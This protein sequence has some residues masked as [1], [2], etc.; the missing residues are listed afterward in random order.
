MTLL[1]QLLDRAAASNPRA[2]VLAYG[3]QVLTLSQLRAG[4]RSLA[5]WLSDTGVSPGDRVIVQA[6]NNP[7][8]AVLIYAIS[9]IGG[10]FIPVHPTTPVKQF[11]YIRENSGAVMVLSCRGGDWLAKVGETH[12]GVPRLGDLLHADTGNLPLSTFN[13]GIIPEDLACMIYTSGS[14]GRPKGVTCLHRQMVF[15]IAAIAEA[16]DYLA[17]DVIFC[18]LPLSF[19]YGLYQLFLAVECGAVLRLENP[20]IGGLG[21]FRALK[22]SRANVLPAVP[23]MIEAL[24]VMG[25]RKPGELPDLRLITNTGA[26]P[27]PASIKTLRGAFPRLGFQ[28]MYGLTECKRVSI[29]PV[30]GDLLKPGTCG[31][32]LRGTRVEVVGED[33]AVLPPNSIGEFVISGPNVMA[34]YWKSEE[35]TNKTYRTQHATLRRLHSGDYGWMDED[36]YLYCE[37]RR[38]DIFKVRG[39]RVSCSEIEAACCEAPVVRHAVMVPPAPGRPST[40]FICASESEFDLLGFLDERLEPYKIPDRIRLID[41]MP[42]T[43]NNKFDRK[44]LV[45]SL[46]AEMHQAPTQK[47]EMTHA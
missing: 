47:Q 21:L 1:H 8:T 6:D 34:G 2:P 38:D 33:G 19:D 3:D 5:R 10:C 40:L 28:L 23:A 7:M 4:A 36:G 20:D 35:L 44:A 25:K 31:R 37:G 41:D 29:A 13:L 30:D 24:A 9:T 17:G 26:A 15:S 43:A 14:T 39:F 45:Q 12:V 11:D 46:Q 27:S 42:R 18:S 32:P 22:K 16:L